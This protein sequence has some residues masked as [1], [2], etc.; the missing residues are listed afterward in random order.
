ME[1]AFSAL[2][3]LLLLLLFAFSTQHLTLAAEVVVDTYGN[4][5]VPGEQY[6]ILDAKNKSRGIEVDQ[7]GHD[8]CATTVIIGSDH[9]SLILHADDDTIKLEEKTDFEFAEVSHCAEPGNWNVSIPG[10]KQ[11]PVVI[12]P[13]E[14]I[15]TMPGWFE[16]A[17]SD[18]SAHEY[19]INFKFGGKDDYPLM[20]KH[21]EHNKD[22]YRMVFCP[23]GV[24]E[25]FNVVFEPV[26][27]P[28]P[29]PSPTPSPPPPSAFVPHIRKVVR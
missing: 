25:K 15:V 20:I 24:Y 6:H 19:Y 12:G 14:D 28:P 4:A 11:Y 8:T 3:L 27:P 2:F 16:I 13:T 17:K 5:V 9:K 10:G 7:V 1:T 21:Y 26:T 22:F 29:T 23:D 18:D